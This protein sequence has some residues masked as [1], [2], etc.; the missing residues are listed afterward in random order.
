[1]LFEID[2]NRTID[3]PLTEGKIINAD[4]PRGRLGRSQGTAENAQDRV[5]TERHAQT[6]GHPRTSFAACLAPEHAHGLSR[7]D[8]A[9]RVAGGERW[10]AFSKGLARTRR[11]GA[12]ETSDL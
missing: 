1:M 3:A 12:A 5:P 11:G 7:P 8:G 6:G 4:H 2:E 10:Q 9:L